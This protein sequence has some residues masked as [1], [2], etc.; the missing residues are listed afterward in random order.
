MSERS[1]SIP[2]L[3]LLEV[4]FNWCLRIAAVVLVLITG[5]YV[6]GIVAQSSVLF[7]GMGA[8]GRALAATDLARTKTNMESLTQFLVLASLVLTIS[9]LGRYY[10]YAEAGLALAVVGAALFFGI[11]LLIQNSP[12]AAGK[13]PA[14]MRSMHFDP[15]LLLASKFGLAGLIAG[16]AGGVH[17]LIHGILFAIQ[18]RDRRPK[19]NAEAAKTAASVRKSNDKFL[20]PCWSLPFC[21]DTE[22]KLCPIRQSKSP[23]WR[24]GRGCYCDQNI[25]LTLSGGSQ[26]AASRGSAG[27][28]SRSATVARPKSMTEKREQCLACPVYLHHQQQKYRVMAPLS[29]IVSIVAIV[30]YWGVLS[31]G[32]PAAMLFLGRSLAGL[33]FGTS[34]N[35]VP[36]WADELSKTTGMMYM[37]VGVSAMVAVAY[38]L[39]AVEWALYKLGI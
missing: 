12:G 4:P 20:G 17:L 23:C 26:Y 28:L 15:R 37:L 27:Y 6:Y 7:Q 34:T 33:S 24:S 31:A 38:F 1:G 10:N 21:R 29:I 30:Y 9:V 35:G 5:Y 19:P 25:I 3:D 22:K 8:D 14:M 32:Y 39:Q 16:G 2:A 18:S 36:A 13:L 11:P